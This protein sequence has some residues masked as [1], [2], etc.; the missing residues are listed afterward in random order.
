MTRPAA[1]VTGGARGIGL[2]CA[3]ALADAGFDI[4]VA[5]LAD[6]APANLAA[7]ITAKAAKFAY[8]RCDIA[9]LESHADLV[10]TAM[11]AFGR[12]D[13]LVNNAG[14]GAVVRGDLLDLKPDNFDRA[15]GINLRGTV[16][17]SQAVA[18]AML[19]QPGDHA[20]SII[21]ITSVSAEMAS[22]ERSEYCMSKAGLSMWVKNLALRLAS[23]NIGVFEL[24]P[25]IIR[26][27]MTAGVTA[28]Y[29]ALIEGGLVPAKRWGE[30][31]DIGAMVAA[32][33]AGRL[34]FSTGSIINVDG[35][36][37]VPRL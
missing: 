25:G 8:I 31:S 26:T 3:E 15:L 16:F 35:A 34:G 1:I 28:K 21:T 12:I 29:D 17:L 23:E 27:D 37:S 32:L 19:R 36:L 6:Q 14:I 20:K 5:D 33:A 24:R 7:N 18:K 4:L 10:D 30:A 22:P 11:R 13:C 2:A 9:N